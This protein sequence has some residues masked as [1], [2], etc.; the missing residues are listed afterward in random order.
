M[1][2][3]GIVVAMDEEDENNKSQEKKT[4]V[5]QYAKDYKGSIV[6]YIHGNGKTLKTRSIYKEIFEKFITV[7]QVTLIN[8]HKIK[9]LFGEKSTDSGSLAE[10]RS[11]A[12]EEANSLATH[13]VKD[14]RTYIP[15]KLAEVQGVISWPIGEDINEFVT[16][17][18]GKFNNILMKEVKVLE[19]TRLLKKSNEAASQQKLEETGV[20]IVTFPGQLLPHKLSLDGLIIPVREYRKREMFCKNCKRYGHT[21]KMC[22]NKKLEKIEFLCLQCKS[23]EHESGN[24]NCPRRKSIEE[25]KFKVEKKLRQTT[26]AEI[27]KR[28]DPNNSMPGNIPEAM[29]VAHLALPTKKQM[30]ETRKID[31]KEREKPPPKASKAQPQQRKLTTPPGFQQTQKFESDITESAIDFMITTMNDFNIPPTFQDFIVKYL[32]PIIDKFLKKLTDTF[33][34]KLCSF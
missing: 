9:V 28:L 25:K 27:L 19:V 24:A 20:V 3:R 8:E 11:L 29:E 13:T 23:N 2:P 16:N 32:T 15:A 21:E 7:S 31:K 30:M 18:K 5:R 6:V 14:A 12:I 10:S 33:M 4:R 1:Q 22:N 17:G 26:Y 34:Q